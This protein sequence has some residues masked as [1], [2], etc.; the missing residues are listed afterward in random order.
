MSIGSLQGKRVVIPSSGNN[1]RLKVT[2]SLRSFEG[3]L[4]EVMMRRIKLLE[5]VLVKLAMNELTEIQ[6][7]LLREVDSNEGKKT[8]TSLTRELSKKYNIP[9]STIKWNLRKLRDLGLIIAGNAETKGTPIR[10]TD[11]GRLVIEHL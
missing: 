2:G 8:L 7:L 3:S 11:A 10:L 4:I 5:N 9:E 6:K 1:V